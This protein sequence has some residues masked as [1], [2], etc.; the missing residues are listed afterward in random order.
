MQTAKRP[1]SVCHPSPSARSTL[2][3]FLDWVQPLPMATDRTAVNREL[4]KTLDDQARRAPPSM[5]FAA[6]TIGGMTV[7]QAPMFLIILWVGIVIVFQIFRWR[8]IA[9]QSVNE[10]VPLDIRLRKI[11]RLSL[12]HGLIVAASII[13]FY[14]MDDSARAIYT[15]LVCTITGVS[16]T[17]SNGYASPCLG[18]VVPT[19]VALLF[20]WLFF[21]A[22]ELLWWVPYAIV[23]LICMYIGFLYNHAGQLFAGFIS[24]INTTSELERVLKAE[25]L[26]SSAKTRFLASA[27][28]DL[29]Q[30]LHTMSLLSAA[31]TM[32]PLDEKSSVIAQNMN[33]AMRDLTAEL[34]SLL[35][36]SKLDAGIVKI[37]E[38]A[39]N[40][41]KTLDRLVRSHL[42]HAQEKGLEI[43]LNSAREVAVYSDKVLLERLFRN[44]LDNAIK[45]TEKGSINVDITRE[46]DQCVVRISDTGIGVE[47]AKQEQIFEEF[48]QIGNIERDRKQGLGL[49]LS[50]VSRIV[51]ILGV[52]IQLDSTPGVGS[53][54][55]LSMAAYDE[56][57]A[58][59]KPVTAAR[60]E[61][62]GAQVMLV[63]DDSGVR[64][65]TEAFLAEAG[66]VVTSATGTDAAL[67]ALSAK[68]QP[69]VVI[70]DIR[71]PDGD[72]GVRA[73][74]RLRERL[75]GLSAILV[76]G[77]TSDDRQAQAR[78][79]G[80]ALL[81][82]PVEQESLIQE[83]SRLLSVTRQQA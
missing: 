7:G 32:R 5:I 43:S 44:L 67:S 24:R 42:V 12:F 53:A 23:V 78:E 2:K 82:K 52:S 34:D 54:F 60:R 56:P 64:F 77:E 17:T 57:P 45:Y 75:P 40:V 51:K 26:A 69:D 16:V 9:Y 80:V 74:G 1:D 65:A 8:Y 14:Y 62:K 55:T 18:F 4:L 10:S 46:A 68:S 83:I 63:E 39:V 13:F 49:G 20:A 71:L 22:Q 48:F 36:I 41:N 35:D 15:M 25:K 72:S 27:S 79:L 21:P 66:C 11:V 3:R 6:L 31:L 38:S 37:D 70:A 33:E 28:H 58:E 30:P 59:T 47:S 76:T 19:L 73:I 50:I 81:T 29:R 61:I